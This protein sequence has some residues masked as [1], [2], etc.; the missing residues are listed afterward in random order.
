MAMPRMAGGLFAI[1]GPGGYPP[2]S[3]KFRFDEEA[4]NREF[5][6]TTV[7]C[8]ASRVP[9]NLQIDFSWFGQKLS[10]AAARFAHIP[11][12]FVHSK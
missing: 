9:P 10:Q 6:Q 12:I 2:N 8:Q 11:P 4:Y 1:M 7:G 3:P 5:R